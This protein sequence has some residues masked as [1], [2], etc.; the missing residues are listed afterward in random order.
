[1]CSA[2]EVVDVRDDAATAKFVILRRFLS[3]AEV[4]AA[5]YVVD[6]DCRGK[7]NASTI[8]MNEHDDCW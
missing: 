3:R 2:E 6:T 1:M 5:E 8:V 4:V 7:R